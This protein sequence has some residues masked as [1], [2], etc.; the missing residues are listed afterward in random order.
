MSTSYNARVDLDRPAPRGHDDPWVDQVIAELDG[1]GPAVSRSWD[2]RTSI[3]LTLPATD[4]RQAVTTT[5]ALVAHAAGAVAVTGLEVLTT[6]ALDR[7]PATKPMPDLLSVTEAAEQ[8][9]VSRQAV[10]QRIEAG[11]LAAARVGTT[12][13]I[14]ADAVAVLQAE[15]PD[16]R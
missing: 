5:L 6:E 10:L 13:A 1:Y 16:P 12:W 4:V 9:G 15:R 8:L 14:P 7:R 2:G 11:K 3:D